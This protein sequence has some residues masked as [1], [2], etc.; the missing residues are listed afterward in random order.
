MEHY[1]LLLFYNLRVFLRHWKP[2]YILKTRRNIWTRDLCITY[3]NSA[4][5]QEKH[6]MTIPALNFTISLLVESFSD[7]LIDGIDNR[8]IGCS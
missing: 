5:Q 4:L 7:H 6:A 2:E 3:V 1:F 8:W